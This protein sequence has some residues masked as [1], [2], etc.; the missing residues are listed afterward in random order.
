MGVTELVDSWEITLRVERKSRQT[1]AS[2]L[3]GVRLYLRWC[4]ANELLDA[5]DRRAV[6]SWVADLLDAGAEAS[7]ARARLLAVRRF[8]NWLTSEREIPADP[9]LGLKSPRIDDKIVQP[10]TADELKAMLKTCGRDYYGVRDAALIRFMVETGV[11]AGEVVAMSI[12]DMDVLAGTA[13]VRR[14]KGGRGRLVPFGTQ[15]AQALDRYLRARRTHKHAVRGELWL[16]H[17]GGF[18]YGALRK[19][20]GDRA[21]TAGVKG[22]H[23]HKL[24]HTAAT[25][26]LAAGGSEGG[27]LAVAGWKQRSMLDRYTAATASARAAEEARGLGLGDL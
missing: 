11:R 3:T 22:F 6:Q 2:Y 10:L 24:R 27:L 5:I 19:T 15:T 21:E 12:D 25:R 13:I 4:E 18:E 17:R 26:W 20:L 23:L 14:G 8:A 1:I 7:T 16:G 9:L